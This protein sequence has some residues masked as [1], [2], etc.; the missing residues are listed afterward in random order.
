M[1][2][3][4]PDAE[5]RELELERVIAE[6]PERAGAA[7]WRAV[8][9]RLEA[10]ELEPP[11]FR[12]WSLGEAGKALESVRGRG[13]KVVLRVPPAAAAGRLRED[14]TYLV[15]GGLGGIGR[16][17]AGWLADRGARWIVLNGRRA[18]DAAAAGAIE[19]L[20]EAGR[21]GAGGTGRHGGRRG[22]GADAGADGG[23]AAAVGGGDPQRGS[24]GG[25]VAGEPELGAVRAGAV[26]EGCWGRG[27]CIG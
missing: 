9:G 2:E 18:P 27:S 10:G 12:A 14:G 24:A 7:R 21:G 25:R 11:G 19:G 8:L 5:C 13:K 17:M 20:R 22:G 16:L 4:R 6:E 26:A 3:V 15:T 23:G 1:A